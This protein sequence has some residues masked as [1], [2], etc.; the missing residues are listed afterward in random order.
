MPRLLLS[1]LI[2]WLAMVALIAIVVGSGLYPR[3]IGDP[4]I[5]TYGELA[6]TIV[7]FTAIPLLVIASVLFAPLMLLWR[8][9]GG[10]GGTRIANVVIG[11]SLVLPTVTIIS[12]LSLVLG[13]KIRGPVPFDWLVVLTWGGL[14]F[15][16]TLP[17]A[18]T[19]RADAVHQTN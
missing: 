4:D 13:V 14:V 12:A 17:V 15:G 9:V 19:S 8:R 3:R 16:L 2:S 5:R 7:F 18:T 10:R 6:E 11:A 1:A